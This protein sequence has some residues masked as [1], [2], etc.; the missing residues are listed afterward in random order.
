MGGIESKRFD[1]RVKPINRILSILCTM[2]LI[3]SGTVSV[4]PLLTPDT[5][6]NARGLIS[7]N[8]FFD[9]MESGPGSWQETTFGDPWGE[10]TGWDHGTPVTPPNPYSGN[11][12]WG[13]NISGNY[14]YRTESWLKTPQFMISDSFPVVSAK[15]SFW[16]I[17][18][19]SDYRP[20][21]DIDGGWVAVIYNGRWHR[22]EPEGGY[23]GHA[24][25]IDDGVYAHRYGIRPGYNGTISSWEKATF[26]LSNYV[27]KWIKI[28]FYFIGTAGFGTSPPHGPPEYHSKYDSEFRG[29]YIDDLSVDIERWDGPLIG[30]DQ[31]GVGLGGETLS[32]T[33][34]IKNWNGSADTVDIYYTDTN[35]WQVRILDFAT[36]LPLEDNGGIPGLPDVYVWG[37]GQVKIIVNVT[38][39]IW[40]T[41]WDVSDLTV[42]HIVSNL[43][44]QKNDTAKLTTKTPFPDV[45]VKEISV[46]EMTGINETVFVNVTI[47]NYGD[48]TVS[49]WVEGILSTMLIFPP[50]LNA[51]S[52]QYISNLAPDRSVVLRWSFVPT[53]PGE[54][55]FMATTLLDVDQFIYNNRSERSIIVH[56][57]TLNW[58]D[59]MEDGGD[60]AFGLWNNSYYSG[61]TTQWEWGKISRYGHIG[62]PFFSMPSQEYCWGTD[63][64]YYY[65][66]DTD[67]YLFTPE[68]KAF[69]FSGSEG[70]TLSFYHYWQIQPTPTGDWGEIVYTFDSDP[71]STIYPTGIRYKGEENNW[72]YEEIDMTSFVSDEPY[73]RFGWQ[74]SE[75]IGGNKFE[76]DTWEG[77]YLDDVSVWAS[78]SMPK[79]LIT[80]IVDSGGN[81]Y[82]EVYNEGSV[83]ANLNDY[84]ITLDR[85]STWLTTGSWSS[86][87]ITPGG[88]AYYEI[89]GGGSLNDQGDTIYIVNTSIPEMLINDVASYG[90]RGTVPDPI[91]GECTARYWDGSS[92]VNEWARDPTPTIG[93]QND[94]PGEVAFQYVVLNEVLFNSGVQEA[95]VE[96]RYV[97]YPG[98]DPGQDI[99]GWIIVVGDSVFTLPP[100]APYDTIS[101]QLDLQSPHYVIN[102][103]MFSNLFSTVDVNGDNIYLYTDSGLFV[104]EVGWNNPHMPDTSLSRVPDGFGVE[105]NGKKHGLM[106][107]HDISSI[108][109]GWQFET[110]PSMS[111]VSIEA[112]TIGRGDL[113]WTIVYQLNITNHQEVEDY[114]DLIVTN[115]NPG[116]I[117]E[118]CEDD[119][120]TI[121]TDN[122]VDGIIDTGLLGS[123]QVMTI[124]V[125]VYVPLINPGDFNEIVI[126]AISS[127]N[128]D[129]WDTATIRT[130]TYPHIEL[131]K[132]A[133]PT[134]IWLNGT[135]MFPQDTTLTLEVKGVGVP[136]TKI[137]YQDVI[138]CMDSSGSMDW[139]DVNRYRIDAAKS[140]VDEMEI[141]DR[142]A[143]V[144]FDHR[145]QLMHNLSSDYLMIKKDLDSIDNSE[146]PGSDG[147]TYIGKALQVAID[148]LINKG[149]PEHTWVII[150]LS[151]GEVPDNDVDVCYDEA[152][153]AWDNGIQ[154]YTIA[155]GQ[156]P[157][158]TLL[159]EIAEISGGKFYRAGP[160]G[161]APRNFGYLRKV[162]HEIRYETT[163]YAIDVSLIKDVLPDY[164]DYLPTSFNVYPDNIT[165]NGSNYTFLEWKLDRILVGHTYTYTF[166]VVSNQLGLVQTNSVADSRVGYINWNNQTVYEYFPEVWVNVKPGPP[167]PPELFDKVIGSDV[168]LYWNPPSEQG[169]D[170]YLIYKSSIQTGFDF[171]DVW[172]NTSLH[173]DN[174]TIP[175]RTTWN[176]TNAAKADY[177]EKE[178]YYIIRAV[179]QI[180]VKSVT[181]NT[182]GKWTKLFPPGMSTF[183][184]PLEPFEINTTDWYTSDIP[185]CDYIRNMNPWSNKW[186]ISDPNWPDVLMAA[187]H[188]ICINA[189]APS[190][191]SY[192]FCGKPGANIRYME[193]ELPAPQ[194]LNAEIVNGVDVKLTWDP[195]AGAD[196]YII[197]KSNRR[198]GLSNLSLLFWWETNYYDPFDTSFIDRDAA[199]L[200][201]FDRNV[202]WYYMVVAAKDPSIHTGFNGTYS[203][204]V[205]TQK[206]YQEYDTLG[207][208]LKLNT[209]HESDWY[210]DAIPNVWGMNY[211]NTVE[212]RWMWHK[213]L[214]PKGAYDTDVVM[215]EG[216]QIS[217][218][219]VTRYSFIGI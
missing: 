144:D 159:K 175:Q 125:K 61:S 96:L 113:G 51:S 151:D 171:S 70:I 17:Y 22:I 174:G 35:N 25:T 87:T 147:Q 129:G 213:T 192:T 24:G 58:F 89:I 148:E 88:H 132:Y 33:L 188:E 118:L 67:C 64:S 193:G 153:R 59:D 163:H 133:S 219:A 164:I 3:L 68:S 31:T 10:T 32:Y 216:Y 80:E 34:N 63:L 204:G 198:E 161:T 138:F 26:D 11:Y 187:G 108:A 215:S 85:G 28:E 162:Y 86:S 152:Y 9:D 40:V 210:C 126:T 110:I 53:A 57:W 154:I 165:R 93:A 156:E 20:T 2:L 115:P 203:L 190:N 46:S 27:G 112:D 74:L 106:G 37:N 160:P 127:K 140:Y 90:Q 121:L 123:N 122:D 84:D 143:V 1:F 199:Y 114:I 82:I 191:N 180:G 5:F 15:L 176:I 211:Y 102:T 6:P 169:V 13:T 200:G 214:M 41:E 217:T 155:F 117:V 185:Y 166:K 181:S 202:H 21:E 184:L 103:S 65:E 137:F 170:H 12:C 179:N 75:N 101:T 43:D 107:Y 14:T 81:E 131:D 111:V 116:W 30:P 141:P 208:P 16:H 105:L 98:N 44:P 194:N 149:D 77:W 119:N 146:S 69:D 62:P 120:V 55:I 78:S 91:P 206:Y 209:T 23:P 205:W 109:A 100:P 76:P 150:L 218:T 8:I 195:V 183:S 36:Y 50:S 182:V 39:P 73:V 49:F 173:P 94:G 38:I 201:V 158:E 196:H 83:E 197:Y 4:L 72:L 52:M 178:E 60:A 45:G 92:Y 47:K 7:E 48:W 172:I 95:F 128:L 212:Q 136:P 207:L 134:E 189:T 124:Y 42:I 167:S 97:G 66:E 79:L 157:N 29:W 130:N 168:Q 142:G 18:N 177:P 104:D 54:Y 135:G 71:I 186:V 56:D 99:D 145:A 139:N 19:F